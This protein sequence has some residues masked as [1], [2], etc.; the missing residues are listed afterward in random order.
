[1]L[2]GQA[3]YGTLGKAAVPVV[4]LSSMYIGSVINDKTGVFDMFDPQMG[5]SLYW[6][7]LALTG[8]ASWFAISALVPRDLVSFLPG[9]DYFDPIELY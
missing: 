8:V 4:L 6:P 3:I 7:K 9:A 2:N 1:M 5:E